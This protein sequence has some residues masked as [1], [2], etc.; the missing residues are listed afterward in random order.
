MTGT[1]KG[2]L[3]QFS[4]AEPRFSLVLLGVF[5]TVGLLLVGIGVYSVIAYTVSRQ[6]QEIGLRM[7]LGARRIDVLSMVVRMGLQ[8]VVVGVVIGL[9]AT[10]AA[11]R[12]LANQLWGVTARDPITLG[13]AVLVMTLAGLAACYFPARRATRVDPMVAL[14]YE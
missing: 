14:R 10:V 1:L 9:L 13:A 7:A 4:Y 3:T 5:A 6:T 2:Y 11:T 12:V 8:L